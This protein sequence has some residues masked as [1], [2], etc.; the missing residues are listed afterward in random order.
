MTLKRLIKLITPPLFIQFGK[1]ALRRGKPEWEYVPEG[2]KTT[3]PNIKGWN[4]QSVLD[5]YIAKW[6]AFVN[7]LKDTAP[8]GMSPEADAEHRTDLAFHNVIMSYGYALGAAARGKTTISMLDWG[9]GI[10]HYYRISK[11]LYPDLDIRYHCKDLPLLA[12]YGQQLFP[13]ARFYSDDTALNQQYDFALAS[14][15]LQY[16]RD[17]HG[18]L[19]GL[20]QATTGYLFITRLPIIHHTDSFVVVQRAYAYGYNTEYLGWCI[21]RSQLL[22]CAHAA[23]LELVREFVIEYP[24]PIYHAPERCDYWGFLFK[25]ANP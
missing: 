13:E 8:F 19:S 1:A 17:W 6:P 11:A 16:A 2:W 10:G 20:A 18:T 23:G 24:P 25:R 22:G 5:A 12:N 15:S 4:V 14:S 7:Q 9:G 21:N 3:D